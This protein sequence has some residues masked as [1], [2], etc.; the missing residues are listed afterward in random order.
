MINQKDFIKK[1]GSYLLL[2]T[3]VVLVYLFHLNFDIFEISDD[4]WFK[5]AGEY[6][7]LFDF[8]K[9]RY[10]HWS[11]RL[12]PD[13]V[14]YLIFKLP[15]VYWR[16]FNTALIVLLGYSISRIFNSKWK[17]FASVSALLILGYISYD[18]LYSGYFW[19]TGSFNYLLPMALGMYIMIPY[20]DSYFRE[21][22][23]HF[24]IKTILLFIA[25]FLFSFSNEQVLACALGAALCYHIT[26]F[27]QKK[28]VNPILLIST[29]LMLI[30]FIIMYVSPGNKLRFV[31]EEARYFPGFSSLSLLGR[32]KIGM[33]WMYQMIS[34]NMIVSVVLI[35]I[36]T[37]I[38]TKPSWYKKILIILSTLMISLH[39]VRS[40]YMMDFESRSK[41]PVRL[42]MD[43]TKLFSLEFIYYVLPFV[44][45]TFFFGILILCILKSVDH[46]IFIG[47]CFLA[48]LTSCILM[49][50]S[51][52]IV[53][54][55]PRVL[56]CFGLILSL[57][58]VYLFH[59]IVEKYQNESY[60][61]F[62]LGI[63]PVVAFLMYYLRLKNQ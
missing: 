34:Q 39:H 15:I 2:V 50:F 32:T 23:H 21:T 43:T 35:T 8:L 38:L 18:V 16:V 53:A 31:F 6:F 7:H 48:A 51:P 3:I 45:W 20:A 11:A 56:N 27:I 62:V 30:G 28:K 5:N 37:L 13:A 4:A 58:S 19:I 12:F 17:P 1:S 57:V 24:S 25:V 36:L 26:I 61:T 33:F 14:A 29:G 41:V 46:P 63:F 60:S 54:S 44:L 49:F 42:F 59:Q 9:W 55:G 40:D 52:T 22:E 10:F 47:L